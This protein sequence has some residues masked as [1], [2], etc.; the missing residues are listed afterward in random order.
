MMMKVLDFEGLGEQIL[1]IAEQQKADEAEAFLVSNKVLTIRLVNNSVFEAKGVHDIGVGIRVLRGGGLGFSST[2]DFSSKSLEKAVKAALDVSKTRKL[3]FKY[4][5]PS[6][7]KPPKV[8]GVYDTKLAKLPSD[9]AVD[10]A[11]QMVEESLAYNRKIADNAGVFNLVVYH[12]LV[13]NSHGLK[14]KDDGTFFEASLTATAKQGVKSSE[15]SEAT[16]GRSLKELKPK[17]IGT[18]AA[19]MAVSGLKAKPLKEGTYPIILDSEPAADINNNVSWLC[20]PMIAKLYY[21]LFL[22]K[23]REKVGSE[24][25]T[26]VDDPLMPKGI[27]SAPIDEEGIPSQKITMIEKGVLKN[28]VYDTF[29]GAMEKKRPTA[30]GARTAFAVGVSSFPGRNYNGEPIPIPRNPYIVPGDWKR[31][32]MVED[33]KNGLLVKRFHYTWLTNPTRGD[34][35]S[36]LRMGLYNVEKGEVAGALKK[37]RL[38]DNLLD[39]LK[40]VDAV[41]DT[42]TVAGEWGAYAHTPIIRTKAHVVPV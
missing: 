30:S 2:A 18:K 15:G 32:E 5:F 7:A 14:A 20:S 33:T 26:V 3:P 27:G 22:D 8:R 35:T 16:A 31:E 29:Y 9:K 25:L 24:E 6:P 42:L 13:M 12:T 21:P 19:E 1:K 38:I 17:E 34:F 41:S 36:V 40:N 39:I 28:F 10:S 4:S 37:S 11:Y 23:L